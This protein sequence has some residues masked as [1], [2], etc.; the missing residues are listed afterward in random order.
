MGAFYN[1][2][3]V[4]RSRTRTN[5]NLCLHLYGLYAQL[6]SLPSLTRHSDTLAKEYSKEAF[7]YL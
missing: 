6:R 1:K 2:L 7:L 3:S 4:I 5:K